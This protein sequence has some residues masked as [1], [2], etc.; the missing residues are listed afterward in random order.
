MKK[1]N[2][3]VVATSLL[4]S[5]NLYAKDTLKILTWKGYVPQALVEKFEKQE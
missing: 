5:G 4:L 1:L 2:I 3:L